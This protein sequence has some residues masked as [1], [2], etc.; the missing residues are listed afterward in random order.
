[1]AIAPEAFRAARMKFTDGLVA[2][3]QGLGYVMSSPSTWP[4]ASVPVLVFLILVGGGSAL[5]ISLVESNMAARLATES[6]GMHVLW[7]VLRVLLWLA[8]ITLAFLVS[9]ALAQPIAGPALEALAK[10]QAAAIG[11]TQLPE[12]GAVAGMARSLRVTL[13]GLLLATPIIIGLTVVELVVPVLVVVTMP[14]KFLTSALMLAWDLFDYPLSLRGAGVR[15]RIAWMSDN[16]ACSLGFGVSVA[17]I[18]LV[19][20]AGL[21]FLPAGVC[22]ATRLVLER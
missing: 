9:L 14:L 6:G 20:G 5:G 4:L 7:Q 22:G 10:K 18:L 17:L 2:P 13:F 15:A 12:T 11:V 3:W 1:M 16:F 21:L 8:A 19:P